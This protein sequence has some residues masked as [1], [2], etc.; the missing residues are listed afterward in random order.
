MAS[1]PLAKRLGRVMTAALTEEDV[2]RDPAAA[3][4][5]AI[6]VGRAYL[7]AVTE[8][9]KGGGDQHPSK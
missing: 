3:V 7:Q 4:E 9:A 1:G 2:R 8:P 5:L 6:K